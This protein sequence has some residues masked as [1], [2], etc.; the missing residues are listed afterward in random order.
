[1]EGDTEAIIRNIIE[2]RLEIC[3][4]GLGSYTRER[5]VRPVNAPT[6]VVILLLDKYL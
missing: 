2:T 1:M 3:Q 5:A 4:C 6:M